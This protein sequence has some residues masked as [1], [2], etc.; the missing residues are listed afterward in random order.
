MLAA[1]SGPRTSTVTEAAYLARCSAAWPAELP[2]PT[3]N[4]SWPSMAL[5]SAPAAP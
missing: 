5:A 2:A 4:T 3:T 1:R